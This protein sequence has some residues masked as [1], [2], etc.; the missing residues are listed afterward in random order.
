MRL[1][2][3]DFFLDMNSKVQT[4]NVKVEKWD[5]IRLGTAKDKI[6]RVKRKIYEM[7]KIFQIMYLIISKIYICE[8]S[9]LTQ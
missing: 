8:S 7:L 2:G 4:T 9:I 3:N 5:C 1:T 6:N